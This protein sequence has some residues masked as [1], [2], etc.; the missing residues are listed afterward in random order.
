M[1]IQTLTNYLDSHNIRYVT[2]SHSPAYTAQKIAASAHISGKSM[3]KSV[4]VFVEGKLAMVVLPSSYKV[5]FDMLRELVGT[6]DVRLAEERDFKDTFPDCE[7]GAMPPFGNLYGVDVFVAET[8]AENDE[9]AFSA[10]NHKEVIQM[11]YKDFENLV[12]PKVMKFSRS[13]Y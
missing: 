11:S 9:I 2:I 3:A 13:Y 1:A 12:Q 8:L 5:D 10:C 4:I 7:L 6:D